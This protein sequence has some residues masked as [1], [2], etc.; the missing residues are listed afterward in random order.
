LVPDCACASLPRIRF[1]TPI[2]IVQHVRELDKPTN[3]GKLF[4]RM[5]EGTRVLPVG[6]RQVPFDPAPLR[7]AKVE[8]QLVY[9][10]K[11]AP[12][13]A[14]RPDVGYVLLDGSWS[15]CA[16]M[17]R[18]LEYVSGLPCVAL[19]PGPPSFWTVRT[20][21]DAAGRSTFD[22]AL[23]LLEMHEGRDAV[24]PL[25]RAFA[26]LTARMLH[27]KGKLPSPEIPAAWDV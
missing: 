27:L 20:Q 16:H 23:Q 12:V 7:E 1:R 5:A 3:T 17:S 2:A 4:A 14:P 9:P 6:V 8:W 21:H 19:P 26:M 10:R 11:E 24:A 13:L 22:A 18:R 25:R 15:Q